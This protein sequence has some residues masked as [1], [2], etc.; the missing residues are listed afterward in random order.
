MADEPQVETVL[1][2]GPGGSGGEILDHGPDRG[3]R[4]G[5]RLR[6]CIVTRKALPP[7]ELIRFVRDPY[8]ELR[9]KHSEIQGGSR[10]ERGE[11][12][13]AITRLRSGM[14]RSLP[15]RGRERAGY[16]VP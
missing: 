9:E 3:R 12:R 6:T 16:G 2:G 14:L 10:T 8:R 5:E 15:H 7:G 4:A 11:D 13:I 1:D